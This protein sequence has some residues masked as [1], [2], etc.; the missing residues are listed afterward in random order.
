MRGTDRGST[1]T[2]GAFTTLCSGL[3]I[4]QSMV[5]IGS[6]FDNSVAEAWCSTLEWEVLRRHHVKT[7]DQARLVISVW[8][9]EFCNA[10]RR[11]S[12]IGMIPPVVF[13]Q[14]SPARPSRP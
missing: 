10:R 2:A 3:K 7:K 8:V 6:C 4:R 12:T 1:Y 14:Y 9:H 13:E 5:R 11:H